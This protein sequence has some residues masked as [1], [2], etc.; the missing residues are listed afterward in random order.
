MKLKLLTKIVKFDRKKTRKTRTSY[1]PEVAIQDTVK[2]VLVKNV[3]IPNTLEMRE[4]EY[5]QENS[6]QFLAS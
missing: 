6:T 4:Q 3:T 2:D 5:E 1:W